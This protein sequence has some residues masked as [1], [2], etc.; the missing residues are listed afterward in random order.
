MQNSQGESQVKKYK[1][2]RL[3]HLKVE[4]W[5]MRSLLIVSPRVFPFH[6]LLFPA[7]ES[8]GA[9]SGPGTL[10][11]R[12]P[13]PHPQSMTQWLGRPTG[14]DHFICNPNSATEMLSDSHKTT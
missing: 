6:I 13:H 9:E 11:S 8:S 12:A 4:N 7:T 2:W 3:F 14:L 1:A 10:L 5:Q